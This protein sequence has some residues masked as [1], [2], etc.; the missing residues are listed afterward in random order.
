M[1]TLV[2]LDLDEQSLQVLAAIF[3]RYDSSVEECDICFGDV[4]CLAD[5]CCLADDIVDDCVADLVY[6][7]LACE[8]PDGC[9]V[10]TKKAAR[11]RSKNLL[12]ATL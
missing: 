7:G 1:T 6:L 4:D 10:P 9:L 8:L 11:Y 12:S 5:D 2:P 3:A